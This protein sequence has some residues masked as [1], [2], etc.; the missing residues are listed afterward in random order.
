MV[1][2]ARRDRIIQRVVELLYEVKANEWRVQDKGVLLA[3]V[4]LQLRER[5]GETPGRD[6]AQAVQGGEG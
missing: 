4:K 5:A 1:T 2:Q 3:A 6:G